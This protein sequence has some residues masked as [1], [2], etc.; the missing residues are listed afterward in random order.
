[1][2][3]HYVK[4]WSGSNFIIGLSS[5]HMNPTSTYNFLVV[6]LSRTYYHL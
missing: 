6:S 2:G 4:N 3:G 1:M 5:I